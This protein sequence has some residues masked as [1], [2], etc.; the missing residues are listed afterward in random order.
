LAVDLSWLRPAQP[1]PHPEPTNEERAEFALAR[2]EK[3]DRAAADWRE[4]GDEVQVERWSAEAARLRARCAEL[5][6]HA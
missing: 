6:G 2:A 4:R 3:A 1:Q 5:R